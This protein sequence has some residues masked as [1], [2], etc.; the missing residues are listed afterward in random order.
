[1]RIVDDGHKKIGR[2]D[3]AIFI[4]ETPYGGVVARFRS[5]EQAIEGGDERRLAQELLQDGRSKLA[6]AAASMR[7]R[8]KAEGA[9]RRL[10]T[11]KRDISQ[12]AN[13]LALMT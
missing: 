3:D 6:A 13:S 9:R 7:K 12:I 10:P 5:Y 11:P 2:C 1:M 8:G 4:V